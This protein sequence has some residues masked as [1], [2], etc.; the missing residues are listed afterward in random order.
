M[1]ALIIRNLPEV[2]VIAAMTEFCLV[3]LDNKYFK[4]HQDLIEGYLNENFY[5]KDI[6]MIAGFIRKIAK[7]PKTSYSA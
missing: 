2:L 7:H 6:L 3:K 1:L 4:I 5:D